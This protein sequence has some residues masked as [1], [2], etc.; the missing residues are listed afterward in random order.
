MSR[1]HAAEKRDI[2]PDPKFGNIVV[3]KFMYA[4]M[5]DGKKSVAEGIVYGALATIESKTKQNPLGRRRLSGVDVR[6]D[7][8]VAVILDWVAAG[9]GGSVLR[10]FLLSPA[11]MR[12]GPVG[13]RHL[14]GILALLDCVSPV[15]GRVEQLA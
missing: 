4:I 1:R 7:T 12:E 14:V 8:E 3:S 2:I 9:H 6:H 13:F 11:I 15:I 5:H 10:F